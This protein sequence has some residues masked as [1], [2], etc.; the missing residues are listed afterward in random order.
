MLFMID[1]LVGQLT[2]LHQAT[3]SWDVCGVMGLAQWGALQVQ[4]REKRKHGGSIKE[5]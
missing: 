5:V 4:V 2:V 1:V 3:F